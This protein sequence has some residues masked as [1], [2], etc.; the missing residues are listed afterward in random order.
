MPI[1]A[2][3]AAFPTLWVAAAVLVDTR[4][5]VLLARR[6]EGGHL[7]GH[8]ELPG[9]KVALGESVAQALQREL[10]EEL[11]LNLAIDS[12][13]AWRFV[14]HR[15]DDRHVVLLLFWIDNLN[16]DM[17]IQLHVHDDVQ[18]VHPEA[19]SSYLVPPADLDVMTSIAARLCSN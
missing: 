8:Y 10:I 19:F 4:G 3:D 2:P 12:T 9:G 16:P 15:Y 5:R 11:E 13:Q 14:E 17:P 7:P 6:P 1:T 18:W